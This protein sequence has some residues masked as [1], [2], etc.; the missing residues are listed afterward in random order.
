MPTSKTPFPG[1]VAATTRMGRHTTR[2]AAQ[3]GG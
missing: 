3:G 1:N 2:A